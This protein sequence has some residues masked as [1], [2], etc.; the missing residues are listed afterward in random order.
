MQ[1]EV[2]YKFQK[3]TKKMFFINNGMGHTLS[4]EENQK[5]TIE[6]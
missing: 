5:S 2:D 4:A 1:K 3:E 6:D